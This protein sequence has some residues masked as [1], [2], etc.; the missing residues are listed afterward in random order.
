MHDTPPP[1]PPR[2]RDTPT[3]L[4]DLCIA[5]RH[6][7]VNDYDLPGGPRVVSAIE[8]VRAIDDELRRRGVDVSEQ[9]RE[10]SEQTRWQ[11]DILLEE[12]RGYPQVMPYVREQDGIRRSLRC[13]LCRRAERPPDAKAFWYCDGCV[14]RII[15]AIEAREPIDGVVLFRT[16]NA[17]CR[18]EHADAETVVASDNWGESIFG[19][20]RRCFKEELGRREGR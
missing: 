10:L 15:G 5:L 3:L 4:T 13:T 8:S 16:Y 20:C 6:V 12:C 14:R 17:G 7:G 2:E 19:N 11:M 1:P 9:M 18:C